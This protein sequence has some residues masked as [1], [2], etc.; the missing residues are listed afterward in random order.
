MLFKKSLLP[1]EILSEVVRFSNDAVTIIG[2]TA[3]SKKTGLKKEFTVAKHPDWVHTVAL[4]K[5][6]EVLL[7]KQFRHGTGEFTL[8][9]P[10]GKMD[11]G[12]TSSVAAS[13]ELFEETGF[14]SG[15]WESLGEVP[16]NPAAN[17]NVVHM[18]L[19][20]DVDRLSSPCPDAGEE[21]ETVVLPLER[22]FAMCVDGRIRQPYTYSTLLMLMLKRPEILQK[23]QKKKSIFERI[24]RCNV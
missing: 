3:K 23:S 6:N 9:L 21:L 17:T 10:G 15:S 18:F 24:F 13:R 11:P 12:E 19:A 7:V 20:K 16:A 2:K 14:G 22:V 4:T 1:W 5:E 8:E